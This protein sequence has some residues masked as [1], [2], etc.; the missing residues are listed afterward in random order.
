VVVAS[1]SPFN[2]NGGVEAGADAEEVGSGLP[3]TVRVLHIVDLGGGGFPPPSTLVVAWRL[4]LVAWR[5]DPASLRW[6]SLR[7]TST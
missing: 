7:S 2:S 3:M 1:P 5:L 6:C 4:D